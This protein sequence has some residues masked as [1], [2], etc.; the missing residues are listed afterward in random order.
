MKKI[1]KIKE[2][3]FGGKLTLL[4]IICIGVFLASCSGSRQSS[5]GG[6]VPMPTAPVS[7][8]SYSAAD[9]QLDCSYFGNNKLPIPDNFRG[10]S[11]G[12]L[13]PSKEVSDSGHEFFTKYDESK[14]LS[15]YKNLKL[16]GAGDNSSYWRWRITFS[17]S[18]FYSAVANGLIAQSKSRPNDVLTLSGNS[19]VKK[20]VSKADIGNIKD[21]KVGARG[22]SG[23][24]AYLIVYTNKNTFLVCK[25]LTIRRTI[26]P[27][28]NPMYGA[29]GGEGSYGS[30]PFKTNLN[31]LPSGYFAMEKSGGKITLYGG[32]YGH[33]VGMPQYA[34]HDLTANKNHSYTDVLK[35]YYPNTTIK[36]MYNIPGV[37]ENIRVGISSSG[38]G[39]AHGKVTMTSSGKTTINGQGVNISAGSSDKI[40]ISNSNGKL[41]ISVGGKQRAQTTGK[42]TIKSSGN[43]IT[44]HGV[45][46]AHTSNPSYRGVMEISSVGKNLKI[47]NVVHIEDYLKQ[48][49]PSEMPKSFGVEALKAQAV[50]ARTYALSDYL[51][52]K[53]Q[54][55]GFHVKDTVESQ[56]YNNQVE[57]NESNEAIKS[58]NGQVMI[59]NESP[60]DAKYFSTSS[61]FIEAANYVW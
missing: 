45:K 49:L 57:N 50:A 18:S 26:V 11:V 48:V 4:F 61:G 21:V 43:Y 24:I 60:V 32:G 35:R 34:A 42:V 53:Y 16:R 12:Y 20:S 23:I 29:K 1:L 5:G 17:E 38:G 3:F 25:E 41:V 58:T 51:K 15:F 14:A 9:Y 30:N 27:G 40:E 56:V 59:H 6:H 28:S 47:I 36:N 46:K 33:G 10:N 13:V 55:E 37:T 22:K 8:P 2:F 19:W 52:N 31:M 54:S 44:L 7:K 39:I